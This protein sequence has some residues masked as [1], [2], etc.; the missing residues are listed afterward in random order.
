MK[1]R[2]EPGAYMHPALNSEMKAELLPIEVI[3]RFRDAL[4]QVG[5]IRNIQG[6]K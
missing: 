4:E 3:V 5:E 1:A 6:D 2:R